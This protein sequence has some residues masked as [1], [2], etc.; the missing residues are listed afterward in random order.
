M[1]NNRITQLKDMI[2]LKELRIQEIRKEVKTL[3]RQL[4][5]EKTGLKWGDLVQNQKGEKGILEYGDY[6]WNWR[7]LKKDGTP[8]LQVT[9]CYNDV[10]KI[11]E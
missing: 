4:L 8:S 6:F 1:E 9:C 11:E 10:V 7:K 5:E 2:K 3:E